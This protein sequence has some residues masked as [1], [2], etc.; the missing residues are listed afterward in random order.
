MTKETE[1]ATADKNDFAQAADFGFEANVEQLLELMTHSVYSEKDVFL[2][3]LISNAADACEKL[4]YESLSDAKL[5]AVANAPLIKISLDQDKRTI[6]IA[7]NGIGMS[8]NDLIS[9]LGAIA[10][11]GTRAFLCSD[12]VS[13]RCGG[14]GHLWN[15]V[16][17]SGNSNQHSASAHLLENFRWQR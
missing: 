13:D 9:A 15:R 12:L 14:N 6:T 8:R 16:G 1:S 17:A 7:D 2:R 3:E 5:A 11:S 10:N 4:R